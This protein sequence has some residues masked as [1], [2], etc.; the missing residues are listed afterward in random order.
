MSLHCLV[1]HVNIGYRIILHLG[2]SKHGGGGGGVRVCVWGV[3]GG[4]SRTFT[5]MLFFKG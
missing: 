3:G 5:E 4:F 1:S 2:S